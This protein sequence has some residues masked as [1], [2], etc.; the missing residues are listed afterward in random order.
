M[1]LAFNMGVG[2]LRDED[3]NMEARP[4]VV[5]VFLLT[6]IFLNLSHSGVLLSKI[7]LQLRMQVTTVTFVM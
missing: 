3:G 7:N 6:V 2:G 5:Y 1:G 4:A